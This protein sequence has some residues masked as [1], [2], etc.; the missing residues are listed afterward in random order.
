MTTTA[1]DQRHH[2][3][4]RLLAIYPQ[5]ERA[6]PE[7]RLR[8]TAERDRLERLLDRFDQG[9]VKVGQGLTT[10]VNARKLVNELNRLNRDLHA[11]KD[12]DE[13]AVAA[14][15]ESLISSLE[16]ALFALEDGWEKQPRHNNPPHYQR[17][18]PYPMG[19][20]AT[21]DSLRLPEPGSS[22]LND[23]QIDQLLGTLLGAEQA[24]RVYQSVDYFSRAVARLGE[25]IDQSRWSTILHPANPFRVQYGAIDDLR[26]HYANR[27]YDTPLEFITAQEEAAAR[28]AENGDASGLVLSLPLYEH[29][30]ELDA[31][32]KVEQGRIGD[33]GYQGYADSRRDPSDGFVTSRFAAEAAGR[34]W[35]ALKQ[36]AESL[37]HTHQIDAD[38][39]YLKRS[40]GSPLNASRR[41]QANDLVTIQAPAAAC[42]PRFVDADGKPYAH[43][44]V[45]CWRYRREDT[46]KLG[47]FQLDYLTPNLMTVG[48]LYTDHDGRPTLNK[49]DFLSNRDHHIQLQVDPENGHLLLLERSKA[50]RP[51]KLVPGDPL[52]ANWFSYGLSEHFRNINAA[53]A[54]FP[55]GKPIRA[56]QNLQNLNFSQVG[57]PIAPRLTE[58][59]TGTDTTGLFELT[60]GYQYGFMLLPLGFGSV[61]I[62]NLAEL[63]EQTRG[64]Q[65]IAIKTEAP[66]SSGEQ[67]V[68][69]P[70]TLRQYSLECFQARDAMHTAQLEMQQVNHYKHRDI[71]NV[72]Q[73]KNWLQ[74]NID[75]PE[76]GIDPVNQSKQ[77]ALHEQLGK[78]QHAVRKTQFIDRVDESLND[79]DS[80]GKYFTYLKQR[81]SY[82]AFAKYRAAVERG[83]ALLE[84]ETL[85][86]QVKAWAEAQEDIPDAQQQRW[87]ETLMGGVKIFDQRPNARWGHS[88]T[89][90]WSVGSS[91]TG[92][93]TSP[94]TALIYDGLLSVMT[95]LA[96]SHRDDELFGRIVLPALHQWLTDPALQEVITALS[97]ALYDEENDDNFSSF[98]LNINANELAA[99]KHT[100]SPL[101]QLLGTAFDVGKS[102]FLRGPGA[103]ALLEG[104]LELS[105]MMLEV[106]YRAPLTVTT[107]ILIRA[108]TLN[109]I[110]ITGLH[111]RHQQTQLVDMMVRFTRSTNRLNPNR[112]LNQRTLTERAY[113]G[114]IWGTSQVVQRFEGY[115]KTGVFLYTKASQLIGFMQHM[116]EEAWENPTEAD[117]KS[118]THRYLE[119]LETGLN[120]AS[121]LLTV[122]G[123]VQFWRTVLNKPADDAL[124]NLFNQR[125]TSRAMGT[126]RLLAGTDDAIG[127]SQWVTQSSRRA[128]SGMSVLST[129]ANRLSFAASAVATVQSLMDVQHNLELSR[130]YEAMRSMMLAIGNGAIVA[131]SLV[132]SEFIMVTLLGMNTMP[133][134]GQVLFVAGVAITVGMIAWDYYWENWG[135]SHFYSDTFVYF[136]DVWQRMSQQPHFNAYIDKEFG[137]NE[138]IK[139][140]ITTIQDHYQSTLIDTVQDMHTHD[141]NTD[142]RIINAL[143]SLFGI[144]EKLSPLPLDQS[145]T[146]SNYNIMAIPRL[147]ENGALSNQEGDIDEQKLINYLKL[148]DIDI[149]IGL[150]LTPTDDSENEGESEERAAR[151]LIDWF[152]STGQKVSTCRSSQNMTPEEAA[153]TE[154]AW[155]ALLEGRFPEGFTI[156]ELAK[157]AF[158]P[159]TNDASQSRLMLETFINRWKLL[160]QVEDEG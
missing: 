123:M 134:V 69:L 10:D 39:A 149:Q 158:P 105:S 82:E 146:W 136:D 64:D 153:L 111:V 77:K 46:D 78:M 55:N 159:I 20:P 84:D 100:N 31:W 66:L 13:P 22:T 115:A 76:G 83:F 23:Q 152:K 145:V 132:G 120:E 25:F 140:I 3:I 28:Y 119:T 121:T 35:R 142:L 95:M 97:T 107:N 6:T 106:G 90:D 143:Y 56:P 38:V 147:L 88:C 73:L 68:T 135:R 11:L 33:G 151:N 137:A 48:L 49:P 92:Q 116:G 79:K 52:T 29:E 62:K 37:A 112:L 30:R 103:P 122:P 101:S 89:L 125:L 40:L 53:I 54:A 87:A 32:I 117:F 65:A 130:E 21:D 75:F 160:V 113:G 34:A 50:S 99:L 9:L 72:E 85:M 144:D 133:V 118:A 93:I 155:P 57:L 8:L 156:A 86:Q 126:S 24:Q 71:Y 98:S 17:H 7:Q 91:L 138:E 124:L 80:A 42:A 18:N 70:R 67:Q 104:V 157:A 2:V 110:A 15:L 14:G 81:E 96:Q 61:A 58:T 43:S 60:A 108:Q 41:E 150:A 128:V 51:Q 5:L 109:L 36:W 1:L 45:L 129:W 12:A 127:L 16:D 19:R 131:G 114:D 4:E 59:L 74:C 26:R 27:G 44:Q 139:G 94:Y 148:N 141:V 47:R 102:T 154:I 63:P